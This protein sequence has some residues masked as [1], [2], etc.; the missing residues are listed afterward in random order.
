MA[1][2]LA[3]IHGTEKDKVNC[4]FFYKV[5]A[6]RHGDAC[7]RNHHR[8]EVSPTILLTN[9]YDN[10]LSHKEEEKMTADELKVVRDGFNV[11]YEDVFN[12]LAERGEIDEMIVCANLNEHMLGNVFVRFHDV[13]GAESAMK[14]L[15]ARYYG[16]RMIQPSYSHVTDFRDA[17]CKQQEAGNC[18]RGGFCN[19]IHVL[20]PNHA[21]KRKLLERQPLR[22]QRLGLKPY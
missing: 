11:F 1:T 14:I 5:G 17:K 7:S 12:E 9:M 4:S 21:L 18:E 15:L 20:E 6:C 13:K 10:P 22:R 19:F 3:T 8:P 2:D 16:G